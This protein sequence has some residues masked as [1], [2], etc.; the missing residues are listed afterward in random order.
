MSEVKRYEMKT[1]YRG[2][3]S[4]DSMEEDKDGGYVDYE[5]YAALK[6]KC[7]ALAAESTRLKSAVTQQIDLRAEI[8]KAGRPPHA[9][10]LVQSIFEAE[11]KVKRAIEETPATDALLAEIERKAIRKFINS[12]EHI[13]RDKLSPYDTEE[14]LEAMRIF[15]E[16][17]GAKR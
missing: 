2:H 13:L 9:D 4:W 14:M 6:A 12:I 10:F 3:E 11:E 5:D 8:K 16:E 1:T 17:Q 15:L 7:A